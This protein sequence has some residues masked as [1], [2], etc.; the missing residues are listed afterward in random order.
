MNKILLNSYKSEFDENA[1]EKIIKAI[2]LGDQIK[3]H[4]ELVEYSYPLLKLIFRFNSLELPLKKEQKNKFLDNFND[5]NTIKKIIND[6]ND[7]T[8]N[9]ILFYRF[10]IL[11]EK[12]FNN[13]LIEN[14]DDEILINQKLCGDLSKLYLKDA[15]DCFY[16]LA[17]ITNIN[18]NNIYR[19][20]CISYIK[21][22]LKYYVDT[23]FDKEKNKLF[24]YREDINNILFSINVKQKNMIKFYV[25]KLLLKKFDDWESF[26]NYY[27]SICDV[28]NDL[29]GFNKTGNILKL[30]QNENFIKAPFL[31]HLNKIREDDEYNELLSKMESDGL[32]KNLLENVFLKAKRY[33]YL[34]IFLTN[35]SLFFY[36]YKNINEI[37]KKKDNFLKIIKDTLHYLNEDKKNI[38]KDILLFINLKHFNFN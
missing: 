31:L 17:N 9:D 13:I 15:I 26:V 22:Y 21:M 4:K 23:L 38:D 35:V 19:L 32:N 14:K 36:S 25:L 29:F 37:S 8:I 5:K 33:N 7:K 1:R 12:Y 20:Y 11:F 6:K 3:N 16:K 30:E 18:L 10:E 24:F 2:L 28:K 27:N 34:Y